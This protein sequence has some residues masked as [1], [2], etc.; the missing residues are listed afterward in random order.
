MAVL[1]FR[2]YY[3]AIRPRRLLLSPQNAIIILSLQVARKHTSQRMLLAI[4]MHTFI[5]IN[6]CHGSY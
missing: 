3:L 1:Q 2:Y 5:I 4:I 6:T